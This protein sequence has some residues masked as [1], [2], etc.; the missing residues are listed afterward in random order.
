MKKIVMLNHK[1]N[2][3]LN[4]ISLY[5]KFLENKKSLYD[6]IVF[7]SV[8]Y[9]PYF[10]ELPFKYG[11]QNIFYEEKGAYTGEVSPS[12]ASSLGCKYFLAG[13]SERRKYFNEDDSLVNKKLKSGIMHNMVGVLCIGED[14]LEKED[15]MH[16]LK[17]ELDK[18]LENIDL[19]NVIIAYEPRWAIGSGESLELNKINIIIKN[20][21]DYIKEKYQKNISVL[22]GGSVNENNFQDIISLDYL[23]GVLIGS[24][25]VDVNK[26]EK[27]LH[28]EEVQF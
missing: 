26:I 13:H 9:I 24:M 4:D 8:I 18:S 16:V 14:L 1:M 23:D 11:I 15:V 19:D 25:S 12:Q 3:N 7:P 6:V 22:Y 10:K 21:K 28:F 2:L 5:V 20:I 17:M 27:V